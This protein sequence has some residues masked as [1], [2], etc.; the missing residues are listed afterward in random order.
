VRPLRPSR[1]L[2]PLFCALAACPALARGQAGADTTRAKTDSARAKSDSS[3]GADIF[4]QTTDL[5][6]RLNGRL[7]SKLDK[8]QNDRCVSSQFFN[9]ASQ[10]RAS[11]QPSFDFQ[12]DVRTGG[13]V[14]DRVHVN[15]NYDSKRE[16][17][18]LNQ[19]SLY[20]E[21]KPKDW[22]QRVDVGNVSLDVPA[23]RYIT[24]GIP[25][26]N[27][28]IQAIARFGHLR[29]RAIVAQQ[30]GNVVRDRVFSVGARSQQQVDRTIDDYQ[31]EARRFFFTVDPT[32]FA[33]YPNL[34]ILNAMQ[35]RQLA[36]SLPDTVRPVHVTLYRLLIGGQPPNPNGP[37]FRIIGDPGSRRGQIYEVL[38]ENVD[39][40]AD[41]SQLWVALVQ[42]LNLNN[43]RLVV[44]YTVRVNGRDTTVATTGGTP[45][46][47]FVSTH[48]QF[49]NLLWD[50]QVRPGD[51]AFAR[52]IRSVY[53]VGGEDVRRE[54]VGITVFT[55][56]TGE[57]EKPLGGSAQTF[58]QLFGLAQATNPSAFD[59]VNRLWPRPGDPVFSLGG[60]ASTR[61]IRDQ[62]L[63]FP[64][65]Q[66][67][68]RA[69]LAQPASNPS[70][71]AIYSAPNEY[72][73]SP[74]HP[75]ALYR[76]RVQYESDGGGDGS[77]IAL[78]STQ[79]RPFSERLTLDD[80]IV[81]KRDLDYV[82]DYDLGTVTFLHAD[83]LFTRLRNVTVRYEETPLVAGVPTSIF[84][85]ASTLPLRHGEINFIGIA[86]HQT[87]TFT[88]PPLGYEDQSALIAGVNGAYTFDAGALARAVGRLPGANPRA[89]AK[90]RLEAEFATSRPLPG[91]TKQA[92][93]ETFENEGGIPVPLVDPS[94]YFSSQPA[95]GTNLS[96]RIGGGSSLDLSRVATMAWQNNGF[97][98]NKDSAVKVTLQQ[99]DP[100]TNIVGAGVQLPEQLLWLTL[101]PLAVGG[102]YNGQ[103]KKFE[104]QLAGTPAGRRWRSIRQPLSAA[105]TDLSRVETLEFWALVDTAAVRRRRN[106]TLVIDLG[107]VS[108]NTVAV[109]PTSLTVQ[110]TGSSVDSVYAG[111]AIVGRD[112]LHSERDP[113]SRSFNQNV[114][115]T[116]LPGDVIPRL[117]F[118]SP[119]STRVL[120]N[121]AMCSRGNTV[122]AK[123]GDTRTNCTVQNGRLD[124]WDL[125]GD[126]VLN[127]DS[128]QRERERL[129]RYV[130]DL[131]DPRAYVRVGV[132]GVSPADTL[133]SAG[134]P[135]CWVKVQ[136]PFGSP[137]ETLNGG[138]LL[139][140]VHTIRLTMISGE[141]MPDN[142]FTQMPIARLLLTGAA[143]LK[144]AASP[145]IGLGGERTSVGFVAAG[146]I[147]T[148]DK[149]STSGLIYES[150]PGVV[151]ES[152]LKLSG[153]ENQRIVINEHALRLTA[154]TLAKYERAEAYTRFPEG[155]RNFMQY[156]EL[157]AWARGRGDGWGLNGELQ[158]FVKIARDANNFYAY[159]TPVNAGPGQAAWNPEVRVDFNKFI[160]LRAKLQNAT[161]QNRPDSISCT[162]ADSALIALS[163]MPSGQIS[164]RFAAC[165]DGYIVY[166]V[167]PTVS[168]PNLESVQ[169]LAV[170]FVRVDSA[171]L[172]ATRIIPGDTLELWVDDIRLANAVSTPGYAGQVGFD[173]SSDLGNVHFNFSHRD[174]NFRQLAETP[175]N[176]AADNVDVSATLRLERFL[177]L[178]FGWA[179]PLTVSHFSSASAPLFVT[180]SDIPGSA[181]DGLRTP[182]SAVTTVSLAMRRTTPLE[183]GWLAPILNHL[184]ANTALNAGQSRGEF[185]TAGSSTFSA[186]VDYAV[187]GESDAR[188]MPGW[189]DH[190]LG[191]LPSWLGGSELVQALR[192][193]QWRTQPAALR[194]SS[195]YA[196]GD[197][198]RSSF[199]KPADSQTDTAR[200]VNGLTNYWRN[201][202]A[203]EL[204]PFSAL[205]ARWELASLRDFRDYGE[206][207]PA[208]ATAT[209]E[210]SRLFGFDGGLERERAL[211][212][213]FAFSPSLRGWFRPRFDYF[214]GYGM[215][216][217]P[218]TTQLLR[219]EDSTG[220]FRL[221]RR[222]NGVQTMNAGATFDLARLAGSWVH[223]SLTLHGLQTT[224]QPLD[225][226]YSRTLSSAFDGTPFTPGL[227]FQL[228]LNG[229]DGFLQDH[230]RLA[231]NAMSTERVSLSI[232]IRLPFGLLLAARTQH[233]AT[234]NW[235]V[236][237]DQSQE[238]IDGEQV[239]LPDLT[240]RA[241]FHP[242]AIERIIASLG[243]NAGVSLTQQRLDVP[244]ASALVARDIRTSRVLRYPLGAN[245]LWNDAGRLSM[246]FNIAS[247]FRV[248][249]LPGSV[250]D[251]R[252]RE[253]SADASRAF[254]LPT[255][256]AMKSDLRARLGFQQSRSTSDIQNGFAA[257]ASSRLADNGRQ[258]ITFNADTDVAE[259]LTFSLQGA[260]IVTFDNNLNRRLTQTVL[261]AVLQIKFYAGELR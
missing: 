141:Q 65:L 32:R 73:Y 164:R 154:T 126:N 15:V 165:A 195:N 185:Q 245:I 24:A 138:P 60:T 21:G 118:T 62:F 132:C 147:S 166:T 112:T 34:D 117:L 63:V 150:P 39:Y 43:E 214:S 244:G 9:I 192:G 250:A 249:S 107:D 198:H 261:S 174:A 225:L 51:P 156:R 49:A 257:G 186:G 124:E 97:A 146:V 196:R 171:A 92:Y 25:Q 158:F 160:A 238:V 42:P 29:V 144:R 120:S 228:G 76:L 86:Q 226:S 18:N 77:R 79:L 170:G 27:Y 145:V 139:Q 48:D 74:Q 121:F 104:W 188:A 219:E 88:R 134:T 143:W 28:G 191:A 12:F 57:L 167:D 190:A 177:P 129:L 181:I 58:L 231:T 163:A 208:A 103:A 187:G 176:V 89:P 200:T 256:W 237:A 218:N 232:P 106:P 205:T 140:R 259:N 33:G 116:G 93:L 236:S 161:L 203:L 149:D 11:F 23:S 142:E 122:L 235:L 61:L 229:V 119:D 82:V 3:K 26:G 241:T 115:D 111:R 130:V 137:L 251:S 260:R 159:R 55:G 253:M 108:E 123:L 204:R 178:T 8:T 17:D 14:A 87:S 71:D 10:C 35:M 78:P 31:V 248:D 30:T 20:Y 96:A 128:S 67:F 127:L 182:R 209:G 206:S 197:D 233:V 66:P 99:I 215:Q 131:S 105:G 173:L 179:M 53:R 254:K 2:L 221:P 246:S 38:R 80:G 94:W 41:P 70:N 45:D 52:E 180:N 184:S 224:L 242:K 7:E 168:P 37:Q 59:V 202:T 84:G 222:V 22:L 211:N 68:A 258:A 216:R 110:R 255:D 135:L 212:T 102:A 75:P 113:F 239:T 101:Y 230:G 54:T 210:R 46:V 153:L 114:N 40:Y 91:G 183:S 83:T 19:I 247:T 133:R 64:S 220:A 50:P 240:L 90:L 157:R 44:A 81:L 151:D 172:G 72:L 36:A 175:S 243:A 85:I 5:G 234:R 13:T 199:S 100:L 217:D 109:A 169:E 125:D 207:T 223:D 252:V 155:P 69:G 227:G 189:W 194:I 6:L 148:Q 47:A 16:F 136:L 193:A 162:G 95:L 4:G 213:T 56:A 152:D 201:S 1:L 98:V